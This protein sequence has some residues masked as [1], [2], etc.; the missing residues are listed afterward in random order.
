MS[1]EPLTDDEAITAALLLGCTFAM[2]NGAWFVNEY[3][4]VRD[5][6]PLEEIRHEAVLTGAIPRQQQGASW[7]WSCRGN[8][9]RDYIAW[10]IEEHKKRAA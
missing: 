4:D 5:H 3:D 8:L 9:A 2:V 6:H 1:G 7:G 10:H